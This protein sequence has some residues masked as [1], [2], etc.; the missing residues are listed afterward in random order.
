[1]CAKLDNMTPRFNFDQEQLN[2]LTKA[3][4]IALNEMQQVRLEQLEQQVVAQGIL[5][6]E[7]R[8]QL[9]KDSRNSGTPPAAMA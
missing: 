5:I 8:N 2:Q 6:Q 7:L 1:M 9:A 3:E 4:L